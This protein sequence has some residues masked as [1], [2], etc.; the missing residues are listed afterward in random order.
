MERDTVIMIKS[1]AAGLCMLSS[2]SFAPCASAESAITTPAD[3][4][5]FSLANDSKSPCGRYGISVPDYDTYNNGMRARLVRLSDGA[6]IYKLKN[7]DYFV[8]SNHGKLE[9]SWQ[10][11]G[12]SLLCLVNCEAKWLPSTVALLEVGGGIVKED[13]VW[14]P[15]AKEAKKQLTGTGLAMIAVL[16]IKFI[17]DGRVELNALAMKR[18]KEAS[19]GSDRCVSGVYDLRTHSI[20]MRPLVSVSFADRNRN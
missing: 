14:S 12:A 18:P 20:K 11:K 5:G 17:A 16:E 19:E 9:V 13:D 6:V 1:V 8:H 10:Q 2:L 3:A 7:A 4:S 15:F